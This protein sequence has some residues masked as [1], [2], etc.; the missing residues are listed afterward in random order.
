M[1]RSPY[2]PVW[3]T[4]KH[5]H[6]E[7]A[8]EMFFEIELPGKAPLGHKPGQF[9]EVGILGIGEAPISVSSSPNRTES[10]D[11]VVRNAGNVTG[12]LHRMKEGDKVCIRGPFGNG[13]DLD[14]FKG[15]DVLFVAG[16]IGLVP[17]RSLIHPVLEERLAF[18]RVHILFGAK[19]PAE[20]LFRNELAEWTNRK[21]VDFHVTVDRAPDGDWTGN[22]GVITRLFPKV[23]FDPKKTLVAVCGPP[24]MYK[25]VVLELM[26]RSVPPANVFLSLER[27]MKCGLGKCGHCQI[28]NVYVCQKGP[29]FSYPEVLKME[30]A[31]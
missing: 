28:N 8:L 21:D 10:F 31:I 11:L 7:T 27:H 14:R 18:G 30:E 1:S 20:L 24:V 12:A 19:S 13:F 3:G 2:V 17:L 25:F 29:V 4:L 15:R 5:I 23:D 26:G 16:G 22:I 6:A 9:V